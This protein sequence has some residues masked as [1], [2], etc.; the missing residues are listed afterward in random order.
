MKNL[1]LLIFFC[2]ISSPV[3]A[4][5]ASNYIFSGKNQQQIQANEQ[6]DS[7]LKEENAEQIWNYTVDDYI[8]R[9]YGSDASPA[10]SNRE[11]INPNE[12]DYGYGTA[13]GVD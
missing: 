3:L 5:S 9:N 10:F 4:K 8:D 1:V 7:A 11:N 13:D 12:S 2:L 6:S